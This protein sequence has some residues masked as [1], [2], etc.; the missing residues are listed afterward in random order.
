MMIAIFTRRNGNWEISSTQVTLI[1]QML[2]VKDALK[3]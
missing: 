3:K 1:N 2:P